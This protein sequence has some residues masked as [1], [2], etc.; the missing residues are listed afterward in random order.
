MVGDS[1]TVYLYNDPTDEGNV[2]LGMGFWNHVR[3]MDLTITKAGIREI[4][5]P[6]TDPS[7][8][9]AKDAEDDSG[10]NL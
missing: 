10:F 6:Y 5:N 4:E 9:D 8:F 3:R 2:K 7:I 1:L